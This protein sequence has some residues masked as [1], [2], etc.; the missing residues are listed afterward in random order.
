MISTDTNIGMDKIQEIGVEIVNDLEVEI[1]IDQKEI[2][3]V[4]NQEVEIEGIRI[5]VREIGKDIIDPKGFIRLSIS[6]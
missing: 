4:I 3:I 1:E 6:F 5:K 2:R